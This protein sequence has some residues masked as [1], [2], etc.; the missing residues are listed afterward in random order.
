M[1]RQRQSDDRLAGLLRHG[2]KQAAA[3]G[4]V[5]PDL[6]GAYFERN[7]TSAES[8]KVE[9]HIA[10]CVHCQQQLA[11]MVRIETA[12]GVPARVETAGQHFWFLNWR[13]L[14]PAALAAVGAFAIWITVQPQAPVGL[15]DKSQIATAREPA[16][17]AQEAPAPAPATR[18]F[19]QNK[20]AAAGPASKDTDALALRRQDV[21]A[22]ANK[23]T[24]PQSLIGRS[25]GAAGVVSTPAPVLMAEAGEQAAPARLA[26][27]KKKENV[28][29]LPEA[30]A[31]KRRA[32]LA[33]PAEKRME[34]TKL[35]AAQKVETAGSEKAQERELQ[36]SVQAMPQA[37]AQ[38]SGQ[39][40]YAQGKIP[41]ARSEMAIVTNEAKPD[42]ARDR[43]QEAPPKQTEEGFAVTRSRA[44]VPRPEFT[45]LGGRIQWLFYKDRRIE[46]YDE[47]LKSG[48]IVSSP[49]TQELLAASAPSEK[50]CWAVGRGGVIIRSVSGEPWKQIGSPVE[51][52]LV[53]IEARDAQNAT[54]RTR[55]GKTYA[56]SDGGRTWRSQ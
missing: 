43:T 23:P 33:V 21:P 45:A 53:S 34:S 48:E 52:D 51:E 39:Q 11:A 29:A 12:V 32:D 47:R 36:K 2:L 14:T 7:L 30:D 46:R 35:A 37:P 55:S 17:A 9:V 28:A 25:Q 22:L 18:A 10:S 56:T 54:V 15:G 49:V 31:G 6:L 26:D 19:E 40:A 50:V 42:A 41:P 1:T 3:P 16:A 4:C 27:E 24:A 44:A 20:N 8:A 5:S 38:V 13:W